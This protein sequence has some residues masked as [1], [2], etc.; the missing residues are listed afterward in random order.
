MEDGQDPDRIVTPVHLFA[1]QQWN[2]QKNDT[3]EHKPASPMLYA[4]EHKTEGQVS[5]CSRYVY[6]NTAEVGRG[7]EV[8]RNLWYF[9]IKHDHE[10]IKEAQ[11][12][13]DI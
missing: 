13:F 3:H 8:Q 2:Y 4:Q 1:R 10:H 6:K 7:I 11:Y 12:N 5:Q 9:D